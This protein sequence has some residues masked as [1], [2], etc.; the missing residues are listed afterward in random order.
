MFLNCWAAVLGTGACSWAGVK[1]G[2]VRRAT[3]SKIAAVQACD[4]ETDL[5]LKLLCI[6]QGLIVQEFQDS[7]KCAQA[8]KNGPPRKA[9]PTKAREAAR[10][11]AI[12]PGKL[13]GNFAALGE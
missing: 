9:G 7:G 6:G 3:S 8:K 1:R 5:I 10:E 12:P 2:F 11:V 4:G 13:C